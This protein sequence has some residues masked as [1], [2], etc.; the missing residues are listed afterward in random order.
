[1]LLIHAV[2]P[3]AQEVKR[4]APPDKRKAA[5]REIIQLLSLFYHSAILASSIFAPV[6]DRGFFF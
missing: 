3:L 4:L 1:M 5:E 2:L 6:P